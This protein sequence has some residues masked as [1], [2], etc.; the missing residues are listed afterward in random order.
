MRKILI[1]AILI[2]VES[3]EL[4]AQESLFQVSRKA[5]KLM[6]QGE[7]KKACG[8]YE[9]S[10]LLGNK[11]FYDYYNAA[12][13]W[14]KLKVPDSAFSKLYHC[15]RLKYY[16]VNEIQNDT[17]FSLLKENVKRW[18]ELIRLVKENNI[19]YQN[20]YFPIKQQLES[21]FKEDQDIRIFRDNTVIKKYGIKSFQVDSVNH[22]MKV[23]DSIHLAAVKQII[24][25]YGWLGYDLIGY[26]ASLTLFLV[27]QHSSIKEQEEYLPFIKKAVDQNKTFPEYLAAIRDRILVSH[28]CKQIYG[29]QVFRDEVSGQFNFYPIDDILNV[30]KRRSKVGLNTMEEYGMKSFG[31]TSFK[32]N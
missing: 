10:F 3:I 5:E 8:F 28:N 16:D 32:I 25:K 1:I 30:N 15:I 2:L 26:D 11:N 24:K 6:T 19:L 31:I 9:K 22:V 21:I 13:C 23:L 18:S 29:T 27:I 12:S 7:F 14:A 4:H 17:D 20:K